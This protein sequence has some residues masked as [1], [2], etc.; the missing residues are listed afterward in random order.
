MATNDINKQLRKE[1][2]ELKRQL[3]DLA[4]KR[5][6]GDLTG[7]CYHFGYYGNVIEYY[8]YDEF[9]KNGRKGLVRLLKLCSEKHHRTKYFNDAS[10]RHCDV[11]TK[12]IEKIE[13]CD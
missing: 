1:N 3:T 9:N 4:L 8:W 7:L 13:N 5:I 6:Y 2:A 11:C 10:G 12:I